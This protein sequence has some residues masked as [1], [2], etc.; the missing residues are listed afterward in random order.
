[1]KQCTDVTMYRCAVTLS[2]LNFNLTLREC[3]ELRTDVVI[4][5]TSLNYLHSLYVCE[6]KVKL[7][8]V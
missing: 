5:D 2:P 4:W 1:M 3:R 6:K 8:A 7:S